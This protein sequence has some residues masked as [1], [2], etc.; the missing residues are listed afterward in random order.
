MIETDGLSCSI[1]LLRSD[2]VG[3]RLRMNKVP[4]KEKYIDE[5]KDYS[6]LQNKN[7]VGIDPG[8]CDI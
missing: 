2:K 4:S 5:L 7:I 1:L 8:K 3:K 6:K